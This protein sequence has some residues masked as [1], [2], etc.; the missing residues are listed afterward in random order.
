MRVRLAGA[1]LGAALGGVLLVSSLV[2]GGLPS[3]GDL[4]DFFWPM[5]AYTASRWRSGAPPLWNPLSGCG[6]PWLAQLQ[7]GVLNPLDAVFL[8]PWPYGPTASI[9][10]HLAVAASGMAAFLTALRR[11]KLAALS[12]A[13]IYAGGGAFLSL[14]P[15]YNNFATAAFLPWLFLGARRASRGEGATTLACSSALAVLGGEPALAVFG[16]LAAAATALATR[17]AG[18]AGG[19]PAGG[20]VLRLAGGLL[21]G[22][23]LSAA[24][25]LPFTLHVVESGRLT[26]ATRTEAVERPVGP[27]DLVDLV[28]PPP[29]PLMQG[30]APGRGAY[31]LTLSLGPLPLLLAAAGLATWEDRRLAWALA[32][33][34]AAGFLLSLGAAGG[35]V[36]LLWKLGPFRGI[37]FPA[38]WF[39]FTHFALAVL[40]GAGMDGFREAPSRVRWRVLL[41]GALLVVLVVAGV[42]AL[43]PAR[44]EG[45]GLGR[46]AGALGSAALGLVLLGRS[47]TPSGLTLLTLSAP[48]AWFSSPLLASLPAADLASPP[49][50]LAGLRRESSGRTFVAVH[51]GR[52]LSRWLADG[53]PAFSRKTVRR[54]HDALSGYSNLLFG[55][56]TA[57]SA[58]PIENPKRARLLGAALSG[59]NPAALLALA[60]VRYLVTPFPTTIPEAVPEM[61]SG[62]V[63][64]YRLPRTAGRLFFPREARIAADDEAFEA[65][66]RPGYDPED[67]A[68]VA[69]GD[70]ALPPRRPPQGFSLARV[71]RDEPERLEAALS[72]S[73]PGLLLL[74]RSFDR[75]WTPRLDDAPVPLLRTNLAF[76]GVLV[77]AGEHRLD[78]RYEPRGYRTG[79]LLSGGAL[80]FLAALVLGGRAPSRSGP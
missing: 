57:G 23:A 31:L 73:Q 19:R 33:V 32:A 61:E 7:S 37:R 5:K 25:T 15:V 70:I 42:G 45:D 63:L 77:P 40:A 48:L 44:A 51:D 68:Y 12:G 28:W 9:A 58:S 24:A 74:T 76:A 56:P 38:R 60:D 80:V 50:S 41:P 47:A 66:R 21:L 1:L 20:G 26:G 29:I 67:L 16:S 34:G 78:L 49:A 43:E 30:G 8:L 64:R 17:P 18:W 59:G 52:L 46:L 2:S 6:E 62:G 35:L 55:V 65:L 79:L 27:S 72:T 71:L 54:S 11:S 22:A 4:P 13:A 69:A 39:A 10:L 36:P 75:G 53:G 14:I 3:R